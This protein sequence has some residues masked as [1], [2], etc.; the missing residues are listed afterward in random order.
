MS[1][2]NNF[3]FFASKRTPVSPLNFIERL[4]CFGDFGGKRFR[5]N[6]TLL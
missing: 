2:H 3:N 4:T 5:T 1:L 6:E